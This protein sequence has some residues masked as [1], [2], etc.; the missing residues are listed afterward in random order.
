MRGIL[1]LSD[2]RG[3]STMRTNSG[4]D[5]H[6]I[7]EDSSQH[8]EYDS[9]HPLNGRGSNS[10][11]QSPLDRSL[12]GCIQSTE[13]EDI[14]HYDDPGENPRVEEEVGSRIRSRR[15]S[16]SVSCADRSDTSFHYF[17][18]IFRP[19]VSRPDPM[20]PCINF[21]AKGEGPSLA[22][23]REAAHQ[24]CH[25]CSL[26]VAFLLVQRSN[27]VFGTYLDSSSATEVFDEDELLLYG[28]ATRF[29]RYPILCRSHQGDRP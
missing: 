20:G 14:Y 19:H 6:S 5:R 17:G 1:P 7:G 13:P 22:A 9:I 21:W 16:S 8:S 2:L 26:I 4:R 12:T 28:R 24:G 11:E 27:H 15:C 23:V 25:L 18:H 10:Q 3:S 29:D